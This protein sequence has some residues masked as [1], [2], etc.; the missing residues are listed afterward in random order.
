M[1]FERGITLPGCSEMS[2]AATTPCRLQLWTV[3]GSSARKFSGP[4]STYQKAV[5]VHWRLQRIRQCSIP[6][7]GPKMQPSSHES[8]NAAFQSPVKKCSLPVTSQKMQPS[9]HESKKRILAVTSLKIQPSNHESKNTAFQSRVH[10]KCILA[11]TSLKFSLPITSPKIQPSSHESKNAAFQSRVQKCS[12]LCQKIRNKC[13][14]HSVLNY[15]LTLV[16]T[17]V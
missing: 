4:Y 10:K 13:R 12:K 9:S 14:R 17:S 6:V 3:L 15:I 5:Q 1:F 2:L 11:V 7:T 8:K 16:L